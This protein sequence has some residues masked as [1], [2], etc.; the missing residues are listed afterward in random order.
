MSTSEERRRMAAAIVNFEA[1]RDAKG[2]LMVYKLPEGDGGGAYEVAGINEK[3]NKATADALVALIEKGS[4]DE[5]ETV[6]AEFIAKDTDV[7]AS[8]TRVPALESYL[9]DC[10]FNRGVKGGACILQRALGVADDGDIG[11]DSRTAMTA[12]EADAAGLLQKLRAAREQYERDVARRDETSKF[13]KGL[14]N[15]W[16][17][18]MAVAKTFP[19]DAAAA[20][21]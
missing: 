10:V 19:M 13:W 6:A 11:Q 9:R 1:R 15:R 7:A 14:V 18:A 20:A 5:A 8:W 12:A 4:F 21:A 17:G 16:N 3:Y 2:H